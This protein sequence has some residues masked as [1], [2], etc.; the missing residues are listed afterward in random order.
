MDGWIRFR[1]DQ[2]GLDWIRSRKIPNYS[3]DFG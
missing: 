2:I 3:K 1:L